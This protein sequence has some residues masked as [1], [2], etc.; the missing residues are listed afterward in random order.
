MTYFRKPHPPMIL[1]PIIPGL[2]HVPEVWVHHGEVVHSQDRRKLLL[3]RSPTPHADRKGRNRRNTLRRGNI[4]G[5][6]GGWERCVK[7][8]SETRGGE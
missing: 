2:I 5:Q 1:R 8:L 4:R 7:R 6:R 3:T